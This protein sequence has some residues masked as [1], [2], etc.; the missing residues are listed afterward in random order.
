MDLVRRRTE[1]AM[2][3]DGPPASTEENM[4]N[5]T[6]A[7]EA[8]EAVAVDAKIE[9]GEGSDHRMRACRQQRT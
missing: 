2:S 6:V 5:E 9:D 8:V 7:V 1:A 4:E 3:E